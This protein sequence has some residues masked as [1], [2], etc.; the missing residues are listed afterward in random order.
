MRE[1]VDPVFLPAESLS[2][3]HR[4]IASLRPAVVGPAGEARG[5]FAGGAG[6]R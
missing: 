5:A 4:A 2:P 1:S 6:P 3:Q